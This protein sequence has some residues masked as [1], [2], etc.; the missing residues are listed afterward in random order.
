MHRARTP[1]TAVEKAAASLPWNRLMVQLLPEDVVVVW[2]NTRGNLNPGYEKEMRVSDALTRWVWGTSQG[3]MDVS[4]SWNGHGTW[5]IS[6]QVF[7]LVDT[8]EQDPREYDTSGFG[9]REILTSA[10]YH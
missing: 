5:V 1:R 6:G 4:V 2:R 9:D 10:P 7:A 3:T 8:D